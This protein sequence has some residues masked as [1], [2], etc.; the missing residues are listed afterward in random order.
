MGIR[1]TLNQPHGTILNLQ[2]C[3]TAAIRKSGE[4]IFSFQIRKTKSSDALLISM[5]TLFCCSAERNY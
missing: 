2:K 4:Q 1:A 3:C 5:I